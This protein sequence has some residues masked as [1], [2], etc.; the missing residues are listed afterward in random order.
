MM[1]CAQCGEAIEGIY[2]K[3]LD[4]FIQVKYFDCPDQKDNTFCSQDCF[5]ESLSL[6]IM[7]TESDKTPDDEGDIFDD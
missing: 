1:R 2:Y 6:E 7:V 4:N 3:C 5:C